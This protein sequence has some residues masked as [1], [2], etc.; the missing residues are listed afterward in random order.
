MLAAEFKRE[1]ACQ[2]GEA[3]ERRFDR[4]TI[5]AVWGDPM[6]P[7]T[8]SGAPHNLAMAL[9]RRGIQ[10]EGFQPSIR[11]AQRL[12]F[13]AGHLVGG[14]GWLAS[15]EQISRGT[16]SRKRRA[17]QVAELAARTG[18]RNFL[19]MGT[20]DL[21]PCDLLRS[22]K[23]YLYCDQTW[24]Q[25]LQYRADGSLMTARALAE[26]EQL[27]RESFRR[28]E[29][30][31]T[32]GAYVR[33]SIVG[34]YGI[35]PSKVTAV[36]SGMGAIEPYFGT[37]SYTAP[38][39]L[40]V[41]KHLFVEKGGQLLLEAFLQALKTRPDLRL[42]IVGDKSV[43]HRVPKH[44][45]IAFYGHLPWHALTALYREANLLVQPMLNDPWGQVYLE[46]LASRT[47]VLGLDRNGLPEIVEGGKHGFLTEHPNPRDLAEVIVDAVSDPKRLAAMGHSG[48]QHVLNAYTWD[49]AA[50]RIAFA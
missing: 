25:S 4:V 32:F 31:F 45:A 50:E 6:H 26:Y 22:V 3:R 27:E 14:N 39:L 23:H 38:R 41:A 7:R 34:H 49:I 47:P 40:F 10:V 46:A 33:D 44:P 5:S 48:Q 43:A 24:F 2:P 21:P 36:G 19:H 9:R 17:L 12:L 30:I 13:A 15:Q 35:P 16:A 28:M 29:H 37:K 18:A 42:S 8:W 1:P 20:F 11:R